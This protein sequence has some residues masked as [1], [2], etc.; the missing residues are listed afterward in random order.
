MKKGA[1]GKP[2]IK[3]TNGARVQKQIHKAKK[4]LKGNPLKLPKNNNNFRHEA[5][6][7]RAVSAAIDK[8]NVQ[9]IAAKV[10]QSGGKMG[11]ADLVKVGKE[12]SRE[13]RRALVKKKVGRVEEKLQALKAK[14]EKQGL[15]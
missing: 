11:T 4:V 5:L 2:A 3:K 15:I 13:Q 1:G 14:A 7:D 10:I 8:K 9:I 6:N 12:L